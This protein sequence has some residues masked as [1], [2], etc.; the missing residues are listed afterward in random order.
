MV[1]T[2]EGLTTTKVEVLMAIKAGEVLEV[3]TN[4]YF[5]GYTLKN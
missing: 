2:V 4:S 1:I 5:T 3:A